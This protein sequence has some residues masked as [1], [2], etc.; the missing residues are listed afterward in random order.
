M[1]KVYVR[2]KDP[3]TAFFDSASKVSIVGGEV[4]LISST[5]SKI[6]AAINAGALIKL[7]KED[8]KKHFETFKQK[9][10][11]A[12]KAN[13][14]GEDSKQYKAGV[15][16]LESR[17]NALFG[18][19]N[20]DGKKGANELIEEIKT[21][22]LVDDVKAAIQGEERTTVLKAA[23]DRIA[24]LER[25]ALEAKAKDLELE[26]DENTSNEDLQKAIETAEAGGDN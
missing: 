11:D 3:N 7:S 14:H 20:K 18:S 2:L 5:S 17:Q 4:K 24:E 1:A 25:G 16:D 12:L 6:L 22:N 26:F 13:G 15:A 8:A 9:R 21:M 10:M 23:A 19:K